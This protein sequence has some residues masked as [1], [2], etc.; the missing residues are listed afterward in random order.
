MVET[1]RATKIEINLDNRDAGGTNTHKRKYLELTQKLLNEAR[2]FYVQFFLSHPEKFEER[3]R[4]YSEKHGTYRERKLNSKELLSWAESLTV[5]T[6]EHPDIPDGQ[7]FSLKFPG[8][9]TVYRRSVIND[10]I[11]KARSYLSHLENWKKSGEGKGKPGLPGANNHPVLYK[12][13]YSLQLSILNRRGGFVRIKVFDGNKW[14]W[15]NY[16]VK[17]SQW[18]EKRLADPEWETRSPKLVIGAKKVFLSIPQVKE[19]KVKK[20][21]ESKLNPDLVTVGVDLNVKNLAVI[22]VMRKG[23]VIETVFIKDKG[24]DQH[25]YRHLKLISKHQHLTGRSAKGEHFDRRLWAHIKRTNLDFAH[26]VS[27]KIAGI[28][29]KYPGS[30][31][32]FE[33]LGRSECGKGGKVKRIN[34]KQA[35]QLRGLIRRLSKYKAFQYGTVT[36][37][38]D[39][40]GTSHYCARC[41]KKGE[42][43][44]SRG[45]KRVKCRWGKL[46]CCPHCGYVANADFNASVNMHHSFY[47]RCHWEKT[48]AA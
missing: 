35:Y 29:A 36:V 10:A 3:V 20:V 45:G 34:R 6:R 7:N 47:R 30:V 5:T 28:C 17:I 37:E 38:T 42:R 4:Y 41:G 14:V 16:P 21:E 43:F 13:T 33:R 24:L 2:A 44:S 23:R 22:T 26:K 9:P 11:G 48:E 46:F 31:L 12:G 40:H 39:P 8:M 18:Q 27:K 1:I 25:R 15:V 32:I 19:V